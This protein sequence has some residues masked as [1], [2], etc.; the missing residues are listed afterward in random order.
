MKPHKLSMAGE[1]DRETDEENDAV[2]DRL[3]GNW[4]QGTGFEWKT[5]V[6]GA[7]PVPDLLSQGQK[8]LQT[9]IMNDMVANN[10]ALFQSDPSLMNASKL[11]PTDFLPRSGQ[12][13]AYCA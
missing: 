12:N 6:T 4:G 3:W 10:L 5:V 11:R 1:V 13:C 9:K 2:S 8:V 7:F